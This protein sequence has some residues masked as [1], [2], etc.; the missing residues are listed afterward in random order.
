MGEWVMGTIIG[1]GIGTTIGIHSPFPTTPG[2]TL[3]VNLKRKGFPSCILGEHQAVPA[4]WHIK[5]FAPPLLLKVQ[6]LGLVF[7]SQV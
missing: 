7:R 5:V 4:G 1:E 3:A 2:R 6:C